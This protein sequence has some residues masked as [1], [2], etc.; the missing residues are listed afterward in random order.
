MKKNLLALALFGI[1]PFA[2]SAQV[3]LNEGFESGSTDGDFDPNF[4]A[5]WETVDSY[6]GNETKYRWNVYYASKGTISGTHVAS[7]DG[8]MFTFEPDGQGPREEILLTPELDLNDTYMLSFNW[9]AA[10]A[11]ALEKKEYDLQVRVAVDGNVDGAQTIWSIQDPVSLKESGVTVFPWTGWQV[12]HSEVDLSAYQ[13]KKVRVAFVYKMMQQIGNVAYVDDVLVQKF[14]PATAPQPKLSKTLYNFGTVFVGSKV[15]SDVISLTNVGKNGLKIEN[16]E[17]PA[18]FSTTLDPASVNLDKNEKVEF[19]VSYFAEL[20]SATDGYIVF[21]TN[22]GDVKLRVAATKEILPNGAT[23]EGFEYGVPPAG[24]T[25]GGWRSTYYALEGDYS[26][27]ASASLDGASRLT[28]PRLDLSGTDKK[29]VQFTAYEEF[30]S[31]VDGAYPENDIT[32]EFSSNG[33]ATWKTVWTSTKVN[34]IDAVTV[35]LGTPNSDNC[36]LRWVYSAV[37]FSSEYVPETSL[38]FL[39]CVVLPKLYG[40][41]GLPNAAA[42][43]S[44]AN[45]A[46][47]LFN[48]KIT[49]EWDRALFANGYKLYVGTDAAATDLVNGEDVGTATSYV[50][51][52]CAYAT[53]YNWKVVP[54]NGKG[55]AADVKTWSF[56]TMAD[57][58]VSTYPWSEAFEGGVSLPT[59]WSME[60]S[61]TSR[62]ST[63][64]INPFEGKT[65]MSANCNESNGTEVSLVTPDFVLPAN[66]MRISFYWGNAMSVNLQKDESGIL[67]NTSKGDDGIDACFFEVYAD[68]AWVQ[69]AVVSDKTNKYW[70]H[71]VIDLAE[72]AGKTVAF[73]WRYVGHDYFNSTGVSLDMITVSSADARKASFNT[74]EWNAGT[75]NFQ[76]S[77]TSKQPVSVLNEGTESL[78]I[79]SVA[80]STSNFSSNLAAGTTIAP[81][82]GVPFTLTF[83]ALDSSKTVTDNMVVTFEGGYS[84]SLPVKG[85]A[86]GSDVRY[87]DFENETA[88]NTNPK[89]FTTIDVDRRGTT[90]MTGMDYPQY[91]APFAFCVQDDADWNN[92]FDPVSGSKVLIAIA[93]ADDSQSDDWIVSQKMKATSES[94]F[95]FYARNWESIYSILPSNR[96]KVEVLVSETSATDRTT[97]ETV[98][99]AFEM[100]YYD[101]KAYNEFNVDLSK[102]AGKDIYIAVRHTVVAGLAAFFDD[103]YFEH[104]SEFGGVD[105]VSENCTVS[106]YPN[107][108]VSVI[109]LK[110]VESADVKIMNMSGAV[111]KAASGVS[112]V[113][114]SDLASGIYLVT[115]E[116]E[117]GVYTTRIVKK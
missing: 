17:L 50:L 4:P 59:G 41:G 100:P 61:G 53:T 13:G 23:F 93:P 12:Y 74:T 64:S 7:C 102:Y 51:P 26:A 67:E 110:G 70:F 30:D 18:G 92:M 103:F 56:T 112:E 3:L 28:T 62:W 46:T 11:S 45:G 60:K 6:L 97:F 106:V 83:K 36:Y 101:E 77:T 81:K 47:D 87:Y 1:L 42:L 19:Q 72:F 44:P 20:T 79:Q 9:K 108:A 109:R 32:L 48:K 65:S 24:W 15:Y 22:G 55:D 29:S 117:Q 66:P 116:S 57:Q 78:K 8:Q 31:D 85:V 34:G 25:G 54:Y 99:P 90:M 114:V 37:E 75:V 38:F 111:V 107:P 95:K 14:T 82:K 16:I 80:F 33:G 10:S 5:G 113:G 69:K 2:A 68:G 52:D 21:K 94:N 89:D 40:A 76:K 71:E 91:G 105:S 98:M 104:F 39:D 84:V 43:L 58:T 96:H 86:L 27:Y 73:R 88:G 35:D 63:N 49:L 115:V